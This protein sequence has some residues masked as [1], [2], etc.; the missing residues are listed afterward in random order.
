MLLAASKTKLRQTIIPLNAID[1]K[2]GTKFCGP[3]AKGREKSNVI[4]FG[5]L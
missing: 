5:R 2:N 4:T 3:M 1:L